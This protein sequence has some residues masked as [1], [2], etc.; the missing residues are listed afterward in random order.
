MLL[1]PHVGVVYSTP[2]KLRVHRLQSAWT[3]H[4]KL[5]NPSIDGWHYCTRHGQGRSLYVLD[6]KWTGSLRPARIGPMRP[7][8]W[9]PAA[10][11]CCCDLLSLLPQRPGFIRSCAAGVVLRLLVVLPCLPA[12]Q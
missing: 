9:S 6:F 5:H 10:G 7:V 1:P 3:E 2:T 8:R 11:R 12:P 4:K